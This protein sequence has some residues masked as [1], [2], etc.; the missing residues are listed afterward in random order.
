MSRRPP[1]AMVAATLLACLVNT[2]IAVGLTRRLDGPQP[3]ALEDRYG[4]LRPRLAGVARVAYVSDARWRFLE[5]RYAL[6]PTV[7][8]PRF[9]EIDETARTIAGFRVEAMAEAAVDGPALVVLFDF[10]RRA[11]LDALLL[12]LEDAARRRGLVLRVAFTDG[13]VTLLE[14]GG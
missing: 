1:V 2:V 3:S 4:D 13:R 6:V 9:V 14:I 8:D 12:E 11:R 10:D 7:L 5:A